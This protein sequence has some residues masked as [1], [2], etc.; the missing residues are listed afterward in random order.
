MD[1]SQSEDFKR[2]EKVFLRELRTKLDSQP[3]ELL[4]LLYKHKL[5]KEL[6]TLF[7]TYMGVMWGIGY[8][9]GKK[10]VCVGC[11]DKGFP[12]AG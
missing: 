11:N 3:K 12:L 1:S 10:Q 9:D 7:Q 4:E 2:W 5:V 6:R 8:T